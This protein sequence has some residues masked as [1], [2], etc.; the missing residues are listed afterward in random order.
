MKGETK[1]TSVTKTS[2][3]LDLKVVFTVADNGGWVFASIDGREQEQICEGGLLR[4]YCVF[5]RGEQLDAVASKWMRQF[6]KNQS[7]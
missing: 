4:G 3:K 1:M 2:R 6:V 7:R 5:C